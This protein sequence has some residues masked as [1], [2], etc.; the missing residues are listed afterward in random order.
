MAFSCK[1]SLL[2]NCCEKISGYAS[3][4][5]ILK[6]SE[7]FSMIM[8]LRYLNLRL[9]DMFCLFSLFFQ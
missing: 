8:S 3:K 6:L 1:I 7:L 9:Q 2:L 4:F 5:I